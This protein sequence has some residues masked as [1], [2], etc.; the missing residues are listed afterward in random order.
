MTNGHTACKIYA[1]QLRY[2]ERQSNSY[3]CQESSLVFLRG[4]QED[5]DYKLGGQKH[6]NDCLTVSQYMYTG[7][8][9]SLTQALRNR[10]S[11]SESR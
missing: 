11:S 3:W 5:G 6:L 8:N 10:S 4:Q 7:Q 9:L 2:E 1:R